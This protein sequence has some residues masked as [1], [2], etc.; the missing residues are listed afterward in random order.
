M[1]PFTATVVSAA[2]SLVW[3]A[4]QE[5]AKETGKKSNFYQIL[6]FIKARFRR[7]NLDGIVV[8]LEKKPTE[9]NKQLFESIL[10]DEL[11]ADP[12]FAKELW[13]MLPDEFKEQAQV[14]QVQ[15]SISMR[16]VNVN[17]SSGVNIGINHNSG[18]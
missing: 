2:T 4:V 14:Q 10:Q 7:N 16:D 18:R 6:D 5:A 9:V 1:D 11:E 3:L 12:K 8:K 13:E 17:R 15:Q